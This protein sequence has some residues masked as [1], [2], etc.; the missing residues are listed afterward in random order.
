MKILSAS[1]DQNGSPSNYDKMS[2]LITDSVILARKTAKSLEKKPNFLK[3]ENHFMVM[4]LDCS[5]T[6][7]NVVSLVVFTYCEIIK[8]F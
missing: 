5:R 8:F 7:I 1:C 2:E 3:G 4:D 6:A